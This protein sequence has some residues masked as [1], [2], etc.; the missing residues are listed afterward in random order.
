MNEIVN[1]METVDPRQ[2]P[3]EDLPEF[4]KRVQAEPQTEEDK[5][6]TVSDSE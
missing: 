3:W 6:E 1:E 2:S 5:E 4:L